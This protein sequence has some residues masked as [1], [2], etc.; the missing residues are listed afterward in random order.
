MRGGPEH[1][2]EDGGRA[3]VE[4]GARADVDDGVGDGGV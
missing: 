3:C 1:L 2:V 4:L